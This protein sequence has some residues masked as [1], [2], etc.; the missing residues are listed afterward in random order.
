MRTE[1]VRR[2]QRHGYRFISQIESDNGRRSRRSLPAVRPHVL[3]PVRVDQRQSSESRR[4]RPNGSPNGS[5]HGR[6]N[7]QEDLAPDV[8]APLPKGYV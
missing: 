8:V 2:R 1:R 3:Q 6:Q 7:L 4:R 5:R